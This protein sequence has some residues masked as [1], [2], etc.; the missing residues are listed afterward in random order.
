MTDPKT[1]APDSVHTTVDGVAID[2][3]PGLTP[4]PI[5]VLADGEVI[6]AYALDRAPPNVEG[7]NSTLVEG[8]RRFEATPDAVD[9]LRPPRFPITRPR[10]DGVVLGDVH[11]GTPAQSAPPAPSRPYR[12]PRPVTEPPPST[13]GARTAWTGEE[14]R[15]LQR[16][17]TDPD[18]TT[19]EAFIAEYEHASAKR[20]TP[21][22]LVQHLAELKV[23]PPLAVL[24]GLRALAASTLPAPPMGVSKAG[25]NTR[26][27]LGDNAALLVALDRYRTSESV[28]QFLAEMRGPEGTDRSPTGYA[29]QLRRLGD[30]GVVTADLAPASA[31][32]RRKLKALQARAKTAGA[33]LTAPAPVAHAA[34]TVEVPPAEPPPPAAAPTAEAAPTANPWPALN[35]LDDLRGLY[36]RGLLDT[37]ALARGLRIVAD[38]LSE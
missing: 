11:V 25:R 24:A 32:L 18:V 14:D 19:A 23:H 2:L 17:A 4:D 15:L 3:T 30:A 7:L 21:G 5:E 9:H 22:A 16:L 1:Y 13:A 37:A 27:T 31:A 34:P 6:P 28:E 20:R 29:E 35:D 10:G 36:L 26:W 12:A 38:R 8:L 33:A